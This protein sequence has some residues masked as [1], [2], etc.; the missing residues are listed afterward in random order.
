MT[1]CLLSIACDAEKNTVMNTA[2]EPIFRDAMAGG[3]EA[4]GEANE[5]SQDIPPV[6]E[7]NQAGVVP[8]SNESNDTEIIPMA[9]SPMMDID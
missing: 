8:P 5:P 3:I 4:G 7:I 1:I 9:G 2:D 6:E